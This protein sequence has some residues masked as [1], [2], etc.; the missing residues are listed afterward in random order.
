V[1]YPHLDDVQLR[2]HRNE[3]REAIQAAIKSL[4]ENR[5]ELQVIDTEI[6]RRWDEPLRDRPSPLTAQEQEGRA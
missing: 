3:V 2:A 5:A 1:T 4:A 6:C